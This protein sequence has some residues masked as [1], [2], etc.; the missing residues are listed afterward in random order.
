LFLVHYKSQKWTVL[1]ECRNY[2]RQT[3][4]YTINPLMAQ[5]PT[6]GPGPPHCRG[7][8]IT[9]RRTTLC[10]TPLDEW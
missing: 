6:S 1:A 8:T 4:R 3:L 9:P 10:K 5:Q 2:K 7:F